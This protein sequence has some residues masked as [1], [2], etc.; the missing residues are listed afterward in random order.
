MKDVVENAPKNHMFFG[1]SILKAFWVD[2]GRGLAAQNPR[3]SHFF[4]CFFE[5]NFEQRFRR[6]ENRKK[7]FQQDGGYQFWDGSVEWL[8][9]WGEK[10]RGVQEASGL[11]VIEKSLKIA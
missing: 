1:I 7:S 4:R 8:A 3:F 10:K 6:P 11:R 2:F 5:V 9:S